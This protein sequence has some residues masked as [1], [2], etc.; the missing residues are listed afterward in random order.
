MKSKLLLLLVGL[1][2]IGA[3]QNQSSPILVQP[4]TAW[5]AV[6]QND[7]MGAPVWGSKDSL[8]AGIR[9]GYDL[10]IGWG[11]EREVADSIVRLEHMAEPVFLSIIQEKNV[12]AILNEHPLL[13]SYWQIDQQAFAEGGHLWHCVLTTQGTFNAQLYH[14]ATGEL[15]K[16][17]PQR[18]RMT[19]YLEYPNPN[20]S[21]TSKPLYE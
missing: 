11:W 1:L 3:C 18:H 8:I 15:L 2:A 19:W 20:F 4:T 17:W 12:S 6:Y 10:R 16:D 7:K 21:Q 14:R 9:K 5:R 13:E